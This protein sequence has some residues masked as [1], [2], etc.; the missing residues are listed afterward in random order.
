MAGIASAGTILT[1]HLP[2]CGDSDATQL[3]RSFKAFIG[4]PAGRV[5]QTRS[6]YQEASGI[7]QAL[8]TPGGEAGSLST[9]TRGKLKSMQSRNAY[10]AELISQP[11]GWV[12]DIRSI[13]SGSDSTVGE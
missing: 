13:V 4:V 1:T 2:A 12:S 9:E 8:A 3:S 11:A 7:P 10:C 5:G 6:T